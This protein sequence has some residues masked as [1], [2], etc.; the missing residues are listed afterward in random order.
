M[1][2]LHTPLEKCAVSNLGQWE[3]FISEE[4]NIER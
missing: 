2:R 3:C 1:S 4:K